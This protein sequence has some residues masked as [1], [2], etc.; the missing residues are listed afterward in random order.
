MKKKK[1]FSIII[2]FSIVLNITNI[3][4]L[5]NENSGGEILLN[6]YEEQAE[7]IQETEENELSAAE[8]QEQGELTTIYNTILDRLAVVTYTTRSA[9][10]DDGQEDR[11]ADFYGGSYVNDDKLVVCFTEEG[12]PANFGEDILNDNSVEFKEVKYSYN[13][14]LDFQDDIEKKFGNYYEEFKETDT[15]EFRLLSSF[16]S[17][18]TSQKDNCIIINIT[19]LTE[20]KINTFNDLFGEHEYIRLVGSNYGIQNAA[21]FKPG[22]A[23]YTLLAR[24]Q[25]ETVFATT[26]MG[27]RA[28]WEP[29]D[30]KVYGFTSCGHGIRETMDKKIYMGTKFEKV[31]GTLRVSK[32]SGSVDASFMKIASGHSIGTSVKYSD[33]YGKTTN[34]DTMESNIYALEVPEGQ[35]VYKVGSTTYRTTGVVLDTN[36][37]VISGGVP[38][39]NVTQTTLHVDEGDSGG[40]VYTYKNFGYMP[41]GLVQSFGE[42]FSVYTKAT[43]VAKTI[44][45]HPY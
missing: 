45:V 17:I 15:S 2:C 3:Q 11:Y 8:I 40:I 6:M 38:L 26:S 19:D 18:G 34:T 41:C 21:T 1:L 42:G 36:I 13:E 14:I 23:L 20:E 27:Y 44:S 32:Y 30:N 25:F 4:S 22:R 29:G 31:M 16:N 33:A 43:R 9:E 39:S 10:A 7:R 24:T 35:T 5:A 12:S 28:Y 37:S